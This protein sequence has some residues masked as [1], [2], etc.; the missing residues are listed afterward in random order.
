MTNAIM[1]KHIT[2]V[3]GQKYVH[4][5]CTRAYIHATSLR[6]ILNT[7][8][9]NNEYYGKILTKAYFINKVI[10]KALIIK[11]SATYQHLKKPKVQPAYHKMLGLSV[12]SR[13]SMDFLFLT[14]GNCCTYVHS[15]YGNYLFYLNNIT[16]L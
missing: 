4:N 5:T 11:A 2:S 16:S 8:L 7:I 1:F 14:R 10:H 13:L 3:H 15:I 9:E 12:A 6:A